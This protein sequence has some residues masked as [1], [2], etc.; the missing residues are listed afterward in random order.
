MTARVIG[1][2]N[3]TG[4]SSPPETAA[5]AAADQ[6]KQQPQA[7]AAR[8][9]LA[10]R[11]QLD[12]GVGDLWVHD[13]ILVGARGCHVGQHMHDVRRPAMS[14]AHVVQPGGPGS[15]PNSKSRT[16][17]FPTA[18]LRHHSRRN[19]RTRVAATLAAAPANIELWLIVW[20]W[21]R[22]TSTPLLQAAD[23]ILLGERSC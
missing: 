17:K 1:M 23:R 11:H 8:G 10:R 20:T 6:P 3:G 2:G 13:R 9:T 19:P 16:K 7:P 12:E 4:G 21:S 15:V 14:M 22:N 5:S 18:D